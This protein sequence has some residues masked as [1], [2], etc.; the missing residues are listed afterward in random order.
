M[1]DAI[2]DQVRKKLWDHLMNCHQKNNAKAPLGVPQSVAPGG[3]PTHAVA[4][5]PGAHGG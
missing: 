5:P 1:A 2:P 4:W 3:A